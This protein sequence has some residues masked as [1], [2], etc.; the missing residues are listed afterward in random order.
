MREIRTEIDIRAS[1]DRVW[2]VLTDLERY[3][4]WNPFITRAGGDLREADGWGSASS[5][6]VGSRCTS[7][8]SCSG[9]RKAEC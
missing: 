4:E 9:W 6:R 5:R 3:P 2:E 8:P 1:T 7:A